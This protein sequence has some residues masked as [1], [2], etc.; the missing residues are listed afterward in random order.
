MSFFV[1]LNLHCCDEDFKTIVTSVFISSVFVLRNSKIADRQP[2]AVGV[3]PVFT[4]T[5]PSVSS[6][7]FVFFQMISSDLTLSLKMSI[8]A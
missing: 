5:Y 6:K 2:P 8:S 4:P 7:T 1:S 3:I